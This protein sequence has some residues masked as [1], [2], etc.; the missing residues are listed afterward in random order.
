[1]SGR[2][3]P[4][5]AFSMKRRVRLSLPPLRA[6]AKPVVL[7]RSSKSKIALRQALSRVFPNLVQGGRA[8]ISIEK[9]IAALLYILKQLQKLVEY[10]LNRIGED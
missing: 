3:R 4:R 9:R 5:I 7:S 2:P 6:M 8:M 10:N 1:M